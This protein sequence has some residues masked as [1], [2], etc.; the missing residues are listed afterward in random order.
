MSTSLLGAYI[1]Q[2]NILCRSY[3]IL[4][5]DPMVCP[6]LEMMMMMM[7]IITIIIIIAII[8]AV[9]LFVPWGW[10]ILYHMIYVNPKSNPSSSMGNCS[11]GVG[12]IMSC[13]PQMNPNSGTGTGLLPSRNAM[14]NLVNTCSSGKNSLVFTL[15]CS[16]ASHR[17]CAQY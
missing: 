1:I 13:T 3:T 7:I 14:L 8:I 10:D 17:V 9:W 2:S 6:E 11:M 4:R 12:D 15:F 5:Q 16:W